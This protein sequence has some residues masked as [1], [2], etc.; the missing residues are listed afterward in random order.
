MTPASAASVLPT[1]RT[2]ERGALRSLLGVAVVLAAFTGGPSARAQGTDSTDATKC[3]QAAQ[4]VRAYDQAIVRSGGQASQGQGKAEERQIAAARLLRCGAF[5]GIEAA[6]TIRVTRALTDPAMLNELVGGFGSFRD[7]AVVNAAME[8]AADASASVPARVFALRTM[9]VVQTGKFWLQYEELIPRKIFSD[10]APFPTCG[11]HLV[12][13]EGK[14][15]WD[16]GVAPPAG[17]ESAL[18][19]LAERLKSDVSQPAEVRAAAS[20]VQYP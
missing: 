16:V 18:R 8:V 19:T 6:A 7:T 12:V 20:C 1:A 9:W 2:V 11:H 10:A 3:R 4:L 5:G 17:F 13:S 14:P 15:I